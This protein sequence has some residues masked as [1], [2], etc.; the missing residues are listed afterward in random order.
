MREDAG[1]RIY[2]ATDLVNYLGCTHATFND[3]RQLVHPVVFP[4]DDEQA[5]LL[6]EKGI[7]HEKA[8]LARLREE[9]RTVA[10]ITSE[11]RL[12]ERVAAT[13]KA[14][15]AG[16]DVVYQGAL[17]GSPWH[18]V[19]DFLLRI[20]GTPSGLGDHAYGVAEHKLARTAQPKHVIQ[21]CVYADILRC[22]QGG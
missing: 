18:G 7:E 19:S 9:G 4:E 15:Q 11:G 13:H 20:N 22:A 1:K 2:S 5:K 12:D 3:L 21:L 17:Y 10:E 16:A 8:Y 6:Q 14:M